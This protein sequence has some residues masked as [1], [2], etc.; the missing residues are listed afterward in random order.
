MVRLLVI[1]ECHSAVWDTYR[2]A[3][4]TIVADI[5][6]HLS[7]GTPVLSLSATLPPGTCELYKKTMKLNDP[8]VIVGEVDKPR[9]FIDVRAKTSPKVDLRRM[10]DL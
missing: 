6:A 9:T 1:D 7:P 8:N 10:F 5:R 2:E 4:R 3:W